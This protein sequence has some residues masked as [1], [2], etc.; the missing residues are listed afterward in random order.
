MSSQD[1]EVSRDPE[2]NRYELHVDG[3]LAGR[4]EY[5]LSNG[6]ITFTHTEVDPT[7]EGRGFASKLVQYA[8]DDVRAARQ[9]NPCRDERMSLSRPV[10]EAIPLFVRHSLYHARGS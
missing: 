8:L 9:Q 10:S 1:V 7:F 4:A 6:L 5:L 2:Q 3:R